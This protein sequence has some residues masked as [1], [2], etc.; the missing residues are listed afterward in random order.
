MMATAGRDARS[1]GQAA[2]ARNWFETRKATVTA[3]DFQAF[4]LSVLDPE[5]AGRCVRLS[6]RAGEFPAIHG[7]NLDQAPGKIKVSYLKLN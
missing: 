5:A 4:A 2:T 7:L 6:Q 3:S 1:V